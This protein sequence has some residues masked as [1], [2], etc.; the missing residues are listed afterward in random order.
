LQSHQAENGGE[1]DERYYSTVDPEQFAG[2][3]PHRLWHYSALTE[4]ER[5]AALTACREL[6]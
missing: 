6:T 1:R 5:A 2:G 3:P 4:D